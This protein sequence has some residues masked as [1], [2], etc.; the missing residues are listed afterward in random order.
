MEDN[1]KKIDNFQGKSIK[2]LTRKETVKTERTQQT[3][4]SQKSNRVSD[5]QKKNPSFKDIHALEQF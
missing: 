4:S 3:R 5:A 1:L 2:D